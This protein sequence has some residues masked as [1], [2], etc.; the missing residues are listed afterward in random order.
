MRYDEYIN[1]WDRFDEV[2]KEEEE[3]GKNEQIT[4]FFAV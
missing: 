2:E 3:E 1:C 4:F